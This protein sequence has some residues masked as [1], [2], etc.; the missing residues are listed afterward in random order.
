M[1]NTQ[2]FNLG[3]FNVP[4]SDVAP[5]SG[6]ISALG[7]MAGF[8]NVICSGSGRFNGVG[9]MEKASPARITHAE[10]EIMHGESGLTGQYYN[11][12]NVTGESIDGVS[13][14]TIKAAEVFGVS[15]ISLADIVM[16]PGQELIIDTENMTA[17]IDGENAIHLLSDDSEF[18]FLAQGD[19]I[20]TYTDNSGSRNINLKVMWKNRWV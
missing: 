7:G 17:T 1:F 14:M 10:A 6:N 4:S 5:A 8:V 19:D 3:K 16:K 12:V 11:R 20:I 9:A 2:K 15:V 13:C 18:F